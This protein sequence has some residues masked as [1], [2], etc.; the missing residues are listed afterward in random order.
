MR[1]SSSREKNILEAEELEVLRSTIIQ[2]VSHEFRTPLG[3]ILG[4]SE[5]LNNGT[6]GE[7]APA[8]QEAVFT[9]ITRAQHLCTIVERI[10]ILMDINGNTSNFLAPL[11][12]RSLIEEVVEERSADA[13]EA[14]LAL[15]MHV[16]TNLPIVSGVQ[17]QLQ[18]AIDCL[19]ENAIKFTPEGGRVE[20]KA[21]TESDWICLTVSDSGI[22]IEKEQ[23]ERIFS[24]F[25]QVNGS[26]SRSYGGLGLGLAFTKTVVEAHGGKLE[27]ES[28]LGQGS[29]FTIK[30]PPAVDQAYAADKPS[31]RFR[32]ILLVDDEEQVTTSLQVGLGNLQNY[33]IVTANSGERALQLLDQQTFDLVI[34]DYK[35]PSVDG[36]TLASHIRQSCPRTA[37]I[38]LTAFGSDKL[39]D[40]AS[41][42]DIRRLLDKPVKLTKLRNVVMETLEERSLT[43]SD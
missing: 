24:L 15:D 14:D 26:I 4:Y 30:L 29:R 36:I 35:M 7:L 42:V 5:L 20:V 2:N 34:T 6:M 38:M 40:Q 17:H 39:R 37:V 9:I 25:Y 33:E 16:E 18:Q 11:T 10:G 41:S 23:L 31:P 28:R 22:G 43:E 12:F 32:R 1:V 21:Y 8:Q 3:V 27:A 19:V 13:A